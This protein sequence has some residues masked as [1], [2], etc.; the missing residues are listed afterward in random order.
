MKK[1]VKKMLCIMLVLAILVPAGGLATAAPAPDAVADDWASLQSEVT[2]AGSTP[3]VIALGNDISSSATLV[4]PAGAN[5][6]LTG[7]YSLTAA[8]DYAVVTVNG[9][10]TLD[11]PAL[12]R[13]NTPAGN[14]NG[15]VVNA[16]GNF[17]MRAGE[18]SGNRASS[19]GGVNINGGTFT[20]YGG[21]ISGNTTSGSGSGAGVYVGL[22]S[23]FT[24]IGGEI[25]GNTAPSNAG[26]GVFVASSITTGQ[27]GT[28]VMD[29]GSI[30]GNHSGGGS[31]GGGVAILRGTFIMNDGLIAQNTATSPTASMFGGGVYLSGG[32]FTMNNGQII[33]NTASS[34]GG[35]VFVGGAFTMD[36]GSISGNRANGTAP[37]S[38]GG[39]LFINSGTASSFTM[40]GGRITGNT[41]NVMGG[42]IYTNRDIVIK[43]GVISGN[44]ANGRDNIANRGGGGGIHISS[45]GGLTMH[46]GE[47]YGNTARYDGGGIW[48]AEDRRNTVTLADAVVF[49]GNASGNGARNYGLDAGLADFPNIR[50]QGHATLPGTH[51]L[52]NFDVNNGSGEEVVTLIIE[53]DVDKHLA[54]PGDILTYTI[55]IKNPFGADV[56]SVIRMKDVI[57]TELVDFVD[58][59]VKRDGASAV[60]D[61]DSESGALEM[62]I[63]NITRATEYT[64]I[65]FQVTVRDEAEGY[66]ITNVAG[67][68]ANNS[69]VMYTGPVKTQVPDG[70]PQ[71]VIV[72]I[73]FEAI[74]GIPTVQTAQAAAGDTYA[75]ALESVTDPTRAG[76]TFLGWFTQPSYGTQILPDT[77]VTLTGDH[78]VYA[79]WG[80][81]DNGE[82]PGG[83][84]PGGGTPEGNIP[85]DER[86][87]DEVPESETPERIFHHRIMEGYPNGLLMPGGFITRS[88]AV[89][90]MVRALIPGSMTDDSIPEIRSPFSDVTAENWFYRYVAIAYAR[91]W[92]EG[93]PDGTFNPNEHITR[94]EFVAL[95]SRTTARA[96]EGDLPFADSETI[97]SWAVNH[98]Y[99]TFALG[100][101]EG[102]DL[103]RFNPLNNITRAEAAT[104]INRRLGRGN[105]T[106]SSIE[107]VLPDLL[108]F[109]DSADPNAWYY[110][111]MIEATNNHWI[112]EENG[113]KTWIQTD[114]P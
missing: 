26:G 64:T 37:N 68:Y 41:A 22:N 106:E 81:S 17:T 45:V 4:I 2:A 101:I 1:T 96:Y 14:S 52:N 74:G 105:L 8:G 19:G 7:N 107:N 70:T 85:D 73:T 5:I 63:N 104:A 80:T 66:V 98:V 112:A 108:I 3:T 25:S 34:S 38:G 23:R 32:S 102:D 77:V 111:Q 62:V 13:S 29:G 100:W 40:G 11:G 88:E 82:K 76:F 87:E 51:L 47:I 83:G 6:T 10:F 59:S 50:W 48:V 94:Q 20:M 46:D 79:S 89:T 55:I 9:T 65:V 86:P 93:Y 97:S 90:I 12:T 57:D 109:S 31:G 15:V 78:T 42:G 71:P 16:T 114:N 61:F 67:L 43:N 21:A 113:T 44:T 58:C 92:A 54:E 72:T 49:S 35:G 69:P 53:K 27:F 28:F 99:T 84:V 24:M 60:Y 110:L 56:S 75:E 39:G 95:L 103:G 18:I 33:E 30:T 91:G 36:G